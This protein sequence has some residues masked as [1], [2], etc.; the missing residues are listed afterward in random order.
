MCF[1]RLFVMGA[2]CTAFG[3]DVIASEPKEIAVGAW[4]QP[5]RDSRGYAVRG[6]LVL[7]ERRVDEERRDVVVYVD[8]QDASEHV[9]GGMRVFCDLGKSDFSETSKTGLICEL[10]DKNN[11][12]VE[13]APF[14]FGGAT[15]KSEWIYLPSD[16]TVR[17]R[18]SPFG[19]WRP[20]ALAITPALNRLWVIA[21]GDSNEYTLD[22]TFTV[23]PDEGRTTIHD[24]QIWRGT[25][26]LPPLKIKSGQ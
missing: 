5:V 12:R 19:V 24:P 17:L 9:G 26:V 8:L 3:G 11:R 6:R 16:A 1:A 18:A 21:D 14:A 7:V 13:S 10:R 25:L 4:S 2:I 15:P 23:D 22:G 20:R